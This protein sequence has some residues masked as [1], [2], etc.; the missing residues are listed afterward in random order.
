M[1][2]MNPGLLAALNQERMVELRRPTISGAALAGSTPMTVGSRERGR[3][4]CHRQP[5]AARQR[6]ALRSRTGWL[7]VGLGLRLA[8]PADG[9]AR[10]GTP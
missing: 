3:P 8:L 7:L 4:A 9:T 6:W 5:G 2:S 1:I 10:T